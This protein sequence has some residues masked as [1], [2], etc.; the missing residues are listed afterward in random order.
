MFAQFFSKVQEAPWYSQFLEPVMDL[1]PQESQLLDIGTGSGKMLALLAK[2][3]SVSSI[4]LDTNEDML[5]EAR[6]KTM[7]LP[8]K[9]VHIHPGEPLPFQDHRFDTVSIC[10][11]LFHLKKE[12]ISTLLDDSRRVLKEKG[13]IIILTPTGRG[14]ILKLSRY[15]W[16]FDNKT[17]FIWYRATKSRARAWT[18]NQIL[19]AYCKENGL[20]YS[21]QLTLH[22]FAQLEI[23]SPS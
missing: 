13:K 1:I 20:E 19:A 11:V 8:V 17:I 9:L 23:I 4:G 5:H 12:E 3:K 10:N 7:G 18:K 21:H 6:Q 22:G 14:G 2:A 15:F 16:G